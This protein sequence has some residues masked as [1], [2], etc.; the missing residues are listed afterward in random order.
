MGLRVEASY[1][2]NQLP[3]VCTICGRH[4]GGKF[5][6]PVRFVLKEDEDMVG[7]VC[8]RCAYGSV[9]LW[10]IA[11]QEYAMRLETQ[12]AVLRDLASRVETAQPAQEGIAEDI[13][14]QHISSS[15][16]PPR[17]PGSGDLPPWLRGN[18]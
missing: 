18:G 10:R 9:D 15:P 16:T 12:A 2:N 7:D 4:T 1:E 5:S 13:I 3:T 11:L 8:E 6:P 14:R 17:R